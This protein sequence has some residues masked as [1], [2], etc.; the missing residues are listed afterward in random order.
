MN[1]LK[2]TEFLIK[3]IVMDE[4]AISLKEYDDEEFITIEVLVNEEEMGRVIGKG[5]SMIK[6][7]R[8]I[9]QAAA[10]AEGLK[11]IRINVEAF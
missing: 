7:I 8:T 11:K 5:G 9:V 2:L 6:S 1:P 10:F 3:S 4:D